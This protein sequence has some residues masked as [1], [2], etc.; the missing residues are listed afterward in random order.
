M[1]VSGEAGAS[2]RRARPLRADARHNIERIRLAAL[3]IFGRNGLTAPLERVAKAAGVT[4]GT[5]YH[6]FKTREAL[7][8]AVVDEL[9]REH[10]DT[11]IAEAEARHGAAAQFDHFLLGIWMVQYDE[12]A[13]S[14]VM[15]KGVPES[16]LSSELCARASAALAGF[17]VRAQRAGHVR[18]EVTMVDLYRFIWERG[19]I[20]RAESRLTRADYERHCEY[21]LR[22]LCAS[23]HPG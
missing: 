9:A 16:E 3:D 12:P 8:D 22:G 18:G 13:V 14:D 21:L 4:K 15:T 2:A 20:L 1:R 5:I 7:V 17:L 19:L 11:L 23:T 6:R 10:V